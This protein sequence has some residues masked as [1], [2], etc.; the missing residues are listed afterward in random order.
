MIFLNLVPKNEILEIFGTNGIL[1]SHKTKDGNTAT[2][3]NTDETG[4]HDAK[5]N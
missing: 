4:G 1:F 3:N 2:H 5:W